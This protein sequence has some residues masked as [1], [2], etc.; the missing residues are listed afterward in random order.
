MTATLR[1][2]ALAGNTAVLLEL[3]PT[4]DCFFAA[5]TGF[6]AAGTGFFAAAGRGFAGGNGLGLEGLAAAGPSGAP[7][8][9]RKNFVGGGRRDDSGI[10]NEPSA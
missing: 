2:R 10:M 8:I 5:G 1:L 6:F 9:V 7:A 4:L 3:P